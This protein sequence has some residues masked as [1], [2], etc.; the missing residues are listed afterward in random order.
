MGKTYLLDCTLRDGGYVN[1]W[2]FGKKAIKGT[3]QKIAKA[4]VDFFEIGFIKK[5][6]Y[7]ENQSIFNSFSSIEEII[8]PKSATM[9]YVGM[10][11][12]GSPFPVDEIPMCDGKSVDGIRVIFKQ[13]K[14]DFAYDYCKDIK[15]KGYLLFV[16]FVSTD[17][18]TDTE[19]IEA[20]NRFNSLN[21]YAM[22]IV[23]TF[24]TIKRKAFTRMVYIADNNMLPEI[25]LG[26]HAHNNLQQAFGNAECMVEMNLKRDICIDAC[27]FGMGRG[28]GNLNLELFADFMNENYST[29][30]KIEPMLEIMDDYL[31]EIYNKRFWGYCLPYYL[32]AINNCHPNYAI[33]YAEKETLTEKSFNELL[34]SIPSNS[35]KIYSKSDAEIFYKQYLD[36]YYDDHEDVDKLEKFLNNKNI[37]VIAPGASIVREKEKIDEFIKHNEPVIISVNFN[38]EHF[39]TDF[40]FSSNIR[41]YSR[42]ENKSVK[43]I[44]TSNVLD[45]GNYDFKLN[46]SSY[47]MDYPD[48]IDNSGLMLLKFLSTISP[49]HVYLAGMDG[50]SL[51]KNYFDTSFDYDF[52]HIE[53]RNMLIQESLRQLAKVIKI[54]FL[55][56]SDYAK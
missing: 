9:K 37:I 3:A 46:F 48:I 17:S 16:Q 53:N 25:I 1:D 26:Y 34:K 14:I 18:Y 24:G 12:C 43:K 15:E 51:E 6:D 54:D 7:S 21:P 4:G 20:I 42:L 31:Q 56:R 33:Y 28:A 8:S 22:S 45:V 30:Y 47:S 19:F 11:D 32:S 36:H 41:R 13:N 39:D 35:K 55:T 49:K 38:S 50:Y 52:A 5:G 44:I 10:I 40:I 29:N 23:D 27:I 2:E